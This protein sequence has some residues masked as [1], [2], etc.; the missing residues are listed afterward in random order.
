MQASTSRSR[1]SSR[2]RYS[3]VPTGV[4]TRQAPGPPGAAG[5]TPAAGRLNTAVTSDPARPAQ[6]ADL[7]GDLPHQPQAMTR[8]AGPPIR[9]AY[10]LAV[11]VAGPGMAVQAGRAGVA[12]LHA[13]RPAPG[14]HPQ[15]PRPRAMPDR[16]GG[17][18]MNLSRSIIRFGR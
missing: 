18:F 13:Q 8:L 9:A 15:L 10:L 4:M 11:H 16:I 6:H 1:C 7:V 5:D 3:R 2:A 17:Q 14:L 12:D